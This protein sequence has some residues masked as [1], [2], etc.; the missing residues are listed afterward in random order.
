MVAGGKEGY[1]T[2]V[3]QCHWSSFSLAFSEGYGQVLASGRNATES[4][5]GA[6]RAPPV[7]HCALRCNSALA[8]LYFTILLVRSI[9]GWCGRTVFSSCSQ[10]R[11]LSL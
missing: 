10:F 5:V 1:S 3:R 7:E 6:V 8:K 11:M 4:F 2:V 9:A